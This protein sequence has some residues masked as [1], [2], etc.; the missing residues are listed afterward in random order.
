MFS[1]RLPA[2]LRRNRIADALAAH[3]DELLDLTESNP[4]RAGFAYPA[5]RILGAFLDERALVYDPES[6]GLASARALVAAHHGVSVDRVM[7]TTSTSEAYAWLFKLL[8]DP[9]DEVLIPRPSYPLFEI[10]AALESI[11]TRPYPLR[12]HHGWFVD[13]DAL[14]AAITKRTRAV[15]VVNPNN[16]TGSYLKRNEL[17]Q[18]VEICR[19]HELALISDEV[20]ADYALLPDESRVAT[21]TGV[22][23]A[24]T[25]S[26][27]GLS[28]LIGLPQMKLGWMV[29]SGP[30]AL[31][32]QAMA[33]LEMIADTYLSVGTP[34][35][36][37]LP[38]LLAVRSEIQAQISRRLAI[39]LDV[40]R[41]GLD[42]RCTLLEP[43][44][45]WCATVRVPHVRNEE[46]WILELIA[47]GVVVQPGYFYDFDSEAYLVVSLLTR[48]DI[49]EKGMRRLSKYVAESC[50]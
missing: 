32:E 12:H 33:R 19:E 14:R 36:Y 18:I 1:S 40:L 39:N 24:L 25:F 17:R 8:C 37:A 3:S 43:E 30:A 6:S 22:E 10:L 5:E 47:H 27:S 48:T 29:V 13:F 28:K 7:L 45:G 15:V 42:P 41:T 16:P 4:T 9:G 21:L 50:G 34:V 26:L 46:Q 44:G 2:D 38:E 20:F 49:F 23:H 31:R 35:Q 11:E